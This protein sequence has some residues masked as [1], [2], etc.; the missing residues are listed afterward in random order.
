[1]FGDGELANKTIH[2]LN[3][4]YFNKQA[5]KHELRSTVR[6]ES[7]SVRGSHQLARPRYFLAI[8]NQP[9]HGKQYCYTILAT[10]AQKSNLDRLSNANTLNRHHR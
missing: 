9:E 6:A 10:V 5:N 7:T 1:V 4:L 8:V 3:S 2:I